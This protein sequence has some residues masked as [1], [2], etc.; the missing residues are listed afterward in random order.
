MRHREI[1]TLVNNCSVQL[2][3]QE[4]SPTQDK[5]SV[6]NI[7]RGGICFQS[8]QQFEL[9]EVVELNLCVKQKSVHHAKGRICYRNQ[10]TAKN[11]S[12]YGLSFLDKFI[13]TD[14]LRCD[15][16]P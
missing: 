12:H 7:S 16:D 4:N 13:D 8:N 2:Q 6:I 9:N 10:Q 15:T 5:Y 3:R 11:T 1:R 14:V